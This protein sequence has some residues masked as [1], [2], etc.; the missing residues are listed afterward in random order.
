MPMTAELKH[1][2]MELALKRALRVEVC[3]SLFHSPGDHSLFYASLM[4]EITVVSFT[5]LQE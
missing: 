4:Y 2:L 3:F 1:Y 5:L